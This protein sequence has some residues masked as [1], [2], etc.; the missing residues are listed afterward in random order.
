MK[1]QGRTLIPMLL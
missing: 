1:D